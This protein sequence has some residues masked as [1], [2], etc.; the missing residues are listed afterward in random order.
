[1]P[2]WN[3]AQCTIL[4]LVLAYPSNTTEISIFVSIRGNYSQKTEKLDKPDVA[5]QPSG[6]SSVSARQI[7]PLLP[8]FFGLVG[9]VGC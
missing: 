3:K 1:M 8:L 5:L 6:Q 7:S 4:I 2:S 9:L